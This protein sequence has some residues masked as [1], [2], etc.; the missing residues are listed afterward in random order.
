MVVEQSARFGDGV[1]VTLHR[2]E[3]SLGERRALCPWRDVALQA[4]EVRGKVTVVLAVELHHP[5]RLVEL[6]EA[7]LQCVFQ[8]VARRHQPLGF[9]ALS[10]DRLQLKHG[11]HRAI[12]IEEKTLLV[13]KVFNPGQVVGET[14]IVCVLGSLIGKGGAPTLRRAPGF[15]TRRLATRVIGH[16][17]S[18]RRSPG[19]AY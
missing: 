11:A 2:R 18:S 5:G 10:A 9:T 14:G 4:F 15:P 7:V 1:E 16:H 13:L 6:V 12:V 19:S 8:G 3:E 17:R